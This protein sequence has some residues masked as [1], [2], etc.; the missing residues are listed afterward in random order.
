[1]K[2]K[3]D[4]KIEEFGEKLTIELPNNADEKFQIEITYETSQEASGLQW[5]NPAQ[6]AGKKH[7]YVF[8]QFQ[9]IHARSVI[10]CQDTPGVKAKYTATVSLIYLRLLN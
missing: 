3:L 9:P 2:F 4:K 5:L 6:T 1:M 10:P 8:S 7:P